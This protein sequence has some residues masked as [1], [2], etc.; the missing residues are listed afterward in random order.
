MGAYV[1]ERVSP[2]TTDY[3]KVTVNGHDF[4]IFLTWNQGQKEWYCC[5]V[6]TLPPQ[7][8]DKSE[9][10]PGLLGRGEERSEARQQALDALDQLF[11]EWP[12]EK[13]EAFKKK[14]AEKEAAKRK[15]EEEK[16][17]KKKAASGKEHD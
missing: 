7:L 10:K 17:A 11:P 3:E 16:L 8:E 4:E 9:H 2:A 13:L 6:G 1:E 15:A 12:A 5:L 14:V